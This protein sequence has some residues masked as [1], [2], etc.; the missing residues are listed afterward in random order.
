[1]FFIIFGKSLLFS[2]FVE[3]KNQW[4]SK[5]NYSVVEQ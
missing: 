1:M 5:L 3:N 2:T 4:N